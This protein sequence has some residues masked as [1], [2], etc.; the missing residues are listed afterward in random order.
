MYIRRGKWVKSMNNGKSANL[1]LYV[2][3]LTS[4]VTAKH[5]VVLSNVELRI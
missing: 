4:Y 3:D 5:P 1:K 2:K